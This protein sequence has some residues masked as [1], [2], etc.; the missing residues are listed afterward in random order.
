[1]LYYC[2]DV[3]DKN[4]RNLDAIRG[5]I[6]ALQKLGKE[7]EAIKYCNKILELFP[8]DPDIVT[9]IVKLRKEQDENM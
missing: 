5:Q 7:K 3:L 2:R 4:P 9:C 6:F 8:Y 1:M